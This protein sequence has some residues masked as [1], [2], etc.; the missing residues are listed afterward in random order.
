[1][2]PLRLGHLLYP[3]IDILPAAQ[4]GGEEKGEMSAEVDYLNHAE[5]V[6]VSEGGEERTVGFGEIGAAVGVSG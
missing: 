3:N 5:T 1:M 6:Y 4:G 2:I